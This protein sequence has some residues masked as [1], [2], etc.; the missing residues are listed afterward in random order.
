VNL[1]QAPD[2]ADVDQSC[3][4]VV[5]LQ[6]SF[7]RPIPGAAGVLHRS[8]FL[9][10]IARL[11]DVPILATEQVPH[12]MG[13]TVEQIARLLPGPA[14]EKAC[15][16]CGGSAHFLDAVQSS[17]RSQFILVGIEA[18]ICVCQTALQLREQGHTVFV[19]L[20]AI[21]ARSAL[22]QEA[23]L[24]RMIH[25]GVTVTHTE[26]VAYEWM[27][28]AEHPKFREALKIVKEYDRGEDL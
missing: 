19:A 24:A 26:S 13:G 17:G 20:D 9:V 3:L 6:E 1:T 5:D 7:L 10:E 11:L 2:L 16:G 4:V 15:F 22:A 18:H 21:S 28:T 14:L 27:R 23:A 8:A 12:R 25:S